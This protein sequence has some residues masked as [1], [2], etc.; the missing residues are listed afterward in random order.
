MR[1]Y[2][3][4]RAL[5][6]VQDLAAL[7]GAITTRA[8][9]HFR[10]VMPGFTHYQHAMIT[11]FGHMLM[12]LAVPLERDLQR[13]MNW[14]GLFNRNPLGGATGAGQFFPLRF[15]RFGERREWDTVRFI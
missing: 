15:L 2:L 5:D 10:T 6:F 9:K 8:R 3:R 12:G 11:T 14:Y 13:F 1:L 7:I 4:D